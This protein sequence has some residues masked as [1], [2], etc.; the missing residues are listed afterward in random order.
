[1]DKGYNANLGAMQSVMRQ[2]F[3]TL[4]FNILIKRNFIDSFISNLTPLIV[5]L[6]MLFSILMTSTADKIFVEKMKTGPGMVL[7]LC[8]ALFF[9]VVFGHL[10]I[11]Q[12]ITVEE[13][14]YLEYFYFVIYL[15]IL[16]TAVISIVFAKGKRL[17]FL[18]YKENL[19]SKLLYWPVI[20][21]ALFVITL[22]TFY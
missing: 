14:F 11:R 16:L 17:M 1:M 15:T 2:N 3:P 7:S 21:G 22:F 12:R 20:M 9:V 4:R 19:V 18:Q 6:F 13:I 8:S 5:V 10:G